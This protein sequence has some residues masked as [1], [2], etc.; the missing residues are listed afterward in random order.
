MRPEMTAPLELGRE[1]AS[2]HAWADATDSLMAADAAGPL[3]PD[4]L[5]L[6]G[7][8]AWWAGHR[9]VATEALERAFAG[10]EE[11]GRAEDAGRVAA[12]LA[13]QAFR[14]LNGAVGG[15]WVA[16]ANR[17]L[18][19]IEDSPLRAHLGVYETFAALMEGRFEAGIELA[20]RTMDVARRLGSADALYAAMSFKGVA[21]LRTGRW[22]SGIAL[23]DEAAAAASTGRLDLRVASDIYCNTIAAC[24]DL[25]DLQRAA[26]WTDEA[27]RWMRRQSVG[28]YPGVCQ[29][30]RAELKMLRGEW[31]EAEQDARRACTDLERFGLLDAVGFAQYQVGEIRLRMGDLDAAAEAFDRAYEFGHDAMP[32][33]ALLEL[34]RGDVDGARHSIERALAQA[35]GIGALSDRALRAR[36]L[37]TQVEIALTS[38]DLETAGRAVAE[39]EAIATDYARPLFQAGAMTARGELLLGEDRPTEASPILG[40]SWRLWRTVDLPYESAKARLHYAEALAAEGDEATARR[41]LLAARS[42]F[43]R[44]GA[45]LDLARVDT[46]LGLRGGQAALPGPPEARVPKTFMFTDIVTSTD[47]VG[48]IGDDAWSELL[49]WHDR[50][51]RA[52]VAQHSGEVVN[53]TGDGFFVAFERAADAIQCAIDIQ[54]R[55]VRHRREQGFAPSVRIGLHA[56]EATRRGR[57]YSG[58]GVH[59]AARVGAAAG[60]DEILATDTVALQ[61][62]AH[63]RVSKPRTLA[64]KGVRE[65][66][67][68]RAI[69]WR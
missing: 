18:E 56:A 68:V 58:R 49:A 41:D 67:E 28:G 36:L 10:H 19:G 43:D 15:G 20:D 60:R 25:G 8:S 6:L 14:R 13:Y 17:M 1:A 55:L 34:A 39:L 29:V 9:E 2:R 46:L 37:P 24:R 63:V 42:V 3:S 7:S 54:R 12:M 40:Q 35:S 32:G 21:E 62:G 50:E 26:Q 61:P 33:L 51:L 38:H 27:E 23:V 4:D 30:H 11:A 5:E 45:M 44:L 59:V 66:V 16:Q 64:L 57:D 65:P 22:E 52:A 47:L 31:T 69:D 48:V 53:H